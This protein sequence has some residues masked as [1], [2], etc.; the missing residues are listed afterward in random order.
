MKT[1]LKDLNFGNETADDTNIAELLPYFVEQPQ[2]D[3]FIASNSKFLISTARKGVG[4]SALIQWAAHSISQREPESLIIK[5]RGAD[6]SGLR[7]SMQDHLRT[8]ND[9]IRNWMVKLCAL[10]NRHLATRL[11]MALTEDQI[12]LVEASELEGFRS[13]NL[14]G[15]LVDRLGGLLSKGGVKTRPAADEVALFQRV[16][17]ARLWF[18]IDDLDATFQNT[19]HENL[20]LGTFFSACRYLAQDTE[21]VYIRATMRS[22]VWAILRRFDESLDKVEQYVAEIR[23]SLVEFR[24]LLFLRVKAQADRLGVKISVPAHHDEEKLHAQYFDEVFF[25]KMLWGDKEQLTY[26]VIYTLAYERPRWAIQLCKLA[27]AS[28][29]DDHKNRIEK[30]NFD[31]VWGEYGA[32]RIKD[33]ESEHKHQCSEIRELLNA[34]RGC[35]RLLTRA[36][37]FAWINNHILNHL[38]L[39]IEGQAARSPREIAHFLYR[40]GFIVGRSESGINSYEHYQYSEMPDFLTTRTDQDF[41]VKWE[42]H[43]C[44]REALDIKK[45][46]IS[47]RRG[48]RARRVAD[49]RLKAQFSLIMDAFEFASA[50]RRGV[51]EAF[52]CIKTG[53]MHYRGGG[54]QNSSEALPHDLRNPQEYIAIPH[55]VDLGL[56]KELVFRFAEEKMPDAIQEIRTIFSAPRAYAQFKELLKR[57]RSLNQ[58][59]DYR[60]RARDEALRG[61]CEEREIEVDG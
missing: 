11:K 51:R 12:T 26:R 34:F 50:E 46:D 47:H 55:Q 36:D 48:F 27:Q 38:T 28:A 17:K 31:E 6:L 40:I 57:R 56:G 54:D 60:T 29:L 21:D 20:E 7:T 32:K 42:I 4:K 16:K 25:P 8:P 52:L 24:K 3:A 35:E 9:H 39:A 45:L 59:L 61:W 5:C 49:T 30:S 53:A 1:F 10:A 58:W 23:W 44:Y 18:L 43:P 19:Q 37:L 13:R 14:V 22:D 33:L 2:F 41:S 15:C